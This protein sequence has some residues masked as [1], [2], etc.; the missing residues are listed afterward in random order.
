[1]IFPWKNLALLFSEEKAMEDECKVELT[2]FDDDL[3]APA[4]H[5]KLLGAVSA[6]Y[7]KKR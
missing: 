1:M 5:N 7:D 6:L 3:T 4:A 2:N